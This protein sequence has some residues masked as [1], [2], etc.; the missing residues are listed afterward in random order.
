MLV[1]SALQAVAELF[2]MGNMHVPPSTSSKDG[3]HNAVELN[4]V[5]EV[6]QRVTLGQTWLRSQVGE[7]AHPLY[8]GR[9]S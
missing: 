7:N 5:H 6:P 1:D 3:L 8:S 2:P 9:A 4:S